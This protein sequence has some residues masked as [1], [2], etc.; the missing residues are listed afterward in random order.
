MGKKSMKKVAMKKSQV[1]KGKRAK[2]S[3]FR[4]TKVKTSGGLTKDKLIKNKHG[5]VVSKKASIAAKKRAGATHIIA[6]AKAVS[7][8]RKA[9]GITGFCPVNGKTAQG[10]ALY[11]KAKALY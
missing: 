6:F 2:S 4:G 11:A 1:A 5:K 10:K 3:V 9:L 8:A 7:A